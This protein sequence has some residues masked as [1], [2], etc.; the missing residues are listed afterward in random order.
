[1][2]IDFLNSVI[3]DL[4]ELTNIT[5]LDIQ[6]IKVANHDNVFERAKTKNKLIASFEQKKSKLDSELI[7]LANAN[8]GTDIADIISDEDKQ[9]LKLMK[10]ALNL[11]HQKNK[12][13]A[14]FV[15]SI[16]EFYNSLIESMFP[17]EKSGYQKSSPKPAS[18]LKV[19]A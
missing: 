10:E 4:K 13:Y 19:R 14:R 18:F 12:E 17:S 8:D 7:K 5:E 11:L 9:G 3:D 6:D 1:M 15:V 16:G 2:L